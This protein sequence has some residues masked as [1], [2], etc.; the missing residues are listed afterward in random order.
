MK[1]SVFSVAVIYLF[2]A[3]LRLCARQVLS[4]SRACHGLLMRTLAVTSFDSVM[5][6][7]IAGVM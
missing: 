3:P 5:T 6:S 2:L 7:R 1:F 4:V